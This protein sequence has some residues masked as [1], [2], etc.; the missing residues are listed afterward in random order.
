[1]ALISKCGEYVSVVF[2]EATAGQP[3]GYL[4]SILQNSQPTLQIIKGGMLDALCNE[5]G[6]DI[7]FPIAFLAAAADG[8]WTSLECSPDN[9]CQLAFH[10]NHQRPFAIV[11]TKKIFLATNSYVTTGKAGQTT[12]CKDGLVFF[13]NSEQSDGK[14]DL[15]VQ[16]NGSLVTSSVASASSPPAVEGQ[17]LVCTRRSD[18]VV[19][20]TAPEPAKDRDRDL[21]E[22]VDDWVTAAL[23]QIGVF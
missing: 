11:L 7:W 5:E 19:T 21:F 15:I 13:A 16:I 22:R 8:V 23:T 18:A 1:M 10:A 6:N 3:L 17:L 4:L 12:L 20:L 9:L 14:G 2:S